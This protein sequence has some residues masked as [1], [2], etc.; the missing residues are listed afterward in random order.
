MPEGYQQQLKKAL[1]R[2][3]ER[4]TGIKPDEVTGSSHADMNH[5][6]GQH[7]RFITFEDEAF[8]PILS[9]PA[10][11]GFVNYVLGRNAILSL[12]DGFI[13]G[14]GNNATALHGDN[15]AKHELH[16]PDFGDGLTMN[17][18]LSDYDEE[19]GGLGFVPGSHLFKREPLAGEVQ[20]LQEGR[21]TV[22]VVA[23]AGSL[24]VWGSNTW[25]V[26]YPRKSPGLRL[27]LLMFWVGGKL[28]TQSDFR[29]AATQE[30]PEA[31]ARNPPSFAKVMD[32]FGTFPFREED[33]DFKKIVQGAKP[34]EL[35]ETLPMWRDF[36]GFERV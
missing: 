21:Q 30:Y 15:G 31:L 17:L 1:L 27:T 34:Y 20:S 10:L 5:P 28:Q 19:N 23:K 13:K 14:P 6:I 22:P 18:I 33:F 35:E 3:C 9:N 2:V 12:H 26:A 8:E 29:R 25:H 32:C 24:I 4:R 11:L 7:M 16:Y 36:F